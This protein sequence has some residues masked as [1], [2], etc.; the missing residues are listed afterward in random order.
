MTVKNYYIHQMGEGSLISAH[1]HPSKPPFPA[2]STR[3]MKS[4]TKLKLMTWTWTW[5][6]LGNHACEVFHFASFGWG[7]G[8]NVLYSPVIEDGHWKSQRV[9][10]ETTSDVKVHDGP[11][12]K[13]TKYDWRQLSMADV[14]LAHAGTRYWLSIPLHALY[15]IP[16][17][18][19]FS[20]S[21]KIHLK[22]T[23]EWWVLVSSIA[24]RYPKAFV[25]V[26]NYVGSTI[27]T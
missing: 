1:H 26:V 23:E 18:G 4:A 21:H 25:F 19:N 17:V 16:W 11:C 13:N 12:W 27:S 2:F 6:L 8:E 10:Y 20:H 22:S 5:T 9:N 14:P 15:T 7:M 3:L 24:M